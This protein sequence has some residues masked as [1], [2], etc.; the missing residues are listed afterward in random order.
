MCSVPLTQNVLCH[1]LKGDLCVLTLICEPSILRY[2][3]KLLSSNTLSVFG[4]RFCMEEGLNCS[5]AVAAPGVPL[6]WV[7]SAGGSPIHPQSRTTES[8]LSNTARLRKI[9]VFLSHWESNQ[10]GFKSL[11][12]ISACFK[13]GHGALARWKS[14]ILSS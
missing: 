11:A 4:D 12:I 8:V 14:R 6:G 3:I 10:G 2:S 13:A 5:L 1:G 7:A 9:P